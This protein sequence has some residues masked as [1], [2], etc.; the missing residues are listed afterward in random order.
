M[1]AINHA[2]T[3]LL[4]KKKYTSVPLFAL[5]V[6]VQLMEILWVIFNFLGIEH[7]SVVNG[8]VHLDF[9]PYSHS[10][11]SGLFVSIL[12]FLVVYFILKDNK[13]AIAISIG[14][15]SHILIDI[16]FHEKDIQLTPFHSTPV[17]G[18]GILKIPVL[19]FFLEMIYGIFCWWYFNG[20]KKLLLTIV[21]FN[22]INL[23]FMLAHGDILTI[24]V[25]IPALLPSVILFQILITWYFIYKY[26]RQ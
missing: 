21:C 1:Y 3:A 16:F 22:L 11:F 13:L 20:N 7:F 23:P 14:V 5:L 6:S 19:N 2:A 15:F 18:L 24:F 4:I 8:L 25:K 17:F 10:I 9:L 12:C 26:S